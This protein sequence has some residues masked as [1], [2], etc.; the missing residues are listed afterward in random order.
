MVG[1]DIN[2]SAREVPCGFDNCE[3][4]DLDVDVSWF[5]TA[6]RRV[7]NAPRRTHADIP[8]LILAMTPL[9][10]GRGVTIDGGDDADDVELAAR[11]AEEDAADG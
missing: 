1:S 4:N 7:P 6:V 5:G 11:D 8:A 2:L 9:G 10:H 3:R